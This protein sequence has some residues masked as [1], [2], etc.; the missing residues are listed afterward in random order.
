MAGFFSIL[1]NTSSIALVCG[2]GASSLADAVRFCIIL[3]RKSE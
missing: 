2:H 3:G 1:V